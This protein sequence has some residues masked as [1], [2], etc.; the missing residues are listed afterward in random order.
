[1]NIGTGELIL[2]AVVALLVLGPKRLPELARGLGKMLREFRKQTDEVRNVVEREFYKMDQEMDAPRISPAPDAVAQGGALPAGDPHAHDPLGH[3]ELHAHVPQ[4]V[5][6]SSEPTQ[7]QL[8]LDESDPGH[9]DYYRSEPAIDAPAAA[10]SAAPVTTAAA[11]P[12]SSDATPA[13]PAP[14][15]GDLPKAS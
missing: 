7:A 9:P 12:K 15:G 3:A 11:E 13:A 5:P 2:I 1:M 6:E 10:G 14:A 4:P 8:P